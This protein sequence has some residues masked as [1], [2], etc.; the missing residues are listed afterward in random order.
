MKNYSFNE[1]RELFNLN[2]LELWTI[3]DECEDRVGINTI[4][5]KM[6]YEY[7]I[8]KLDNFVEWVCNSFNIEFDDDLLK[9]LEIVRD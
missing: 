6:K 9:K 5:L 1:L 3:L 7:D 2:Y 8:D 4:Y